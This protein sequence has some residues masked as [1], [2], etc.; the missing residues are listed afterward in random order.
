MAD[1]PK[2]AA[3]V[4]TIPPGEAFLGALGWA[5]FLSARYSHRSL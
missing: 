2:T 3:R 1:E 4:F 5:I